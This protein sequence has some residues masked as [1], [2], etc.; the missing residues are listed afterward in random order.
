MTSTVLSASAPAV[1]D[2]QSHQVRTV[3]IGDV[4]W[5]VCADVAEALGYRDAANAARNLKPRQ[6]GTHNLSTLG[7]TQAVTIINESGL[8]KLV[9]RSRKPEAESFADWVTDDVLPTIR[10]TGHYSA[11]PV[12]GPADPN[13]AAIDLAVDYVVAMRRHAEDPA[14]NPKPSWD[15]ARAEAGRIAHG[16]VGAWLFRNSRWLLSFDHEGNH[17][18]SMI[19]FDACVMSPERML[20]AITEDNGIHVES[21]ALFKFVQAALARLERRYECQRSRAEAKPAKLSR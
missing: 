11:V 9:L 13:D 6:K 3:V 15:E 8:Y 17:A 18:L 7:G 12:S 1:F 19:P 21:A 20:R 5:F 10:K 2:F 4:V 14:A 16:I